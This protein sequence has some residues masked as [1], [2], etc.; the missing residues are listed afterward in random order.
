MT[1]IV[2]VPF[3]M[4]MYTKQP[5]IQDQ[6]VMIQANIVLMLQVHYLL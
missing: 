1:S 6:P 3:C 4:F 2:Q 5:A